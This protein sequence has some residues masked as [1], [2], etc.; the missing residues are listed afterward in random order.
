MSCSKGGKIPREQQ[1]LQKLNE[2]NMFSKFLYYSIMSEAQQAQ[3]SGTSASTSPPELTFSPE[4][5]RD[6]QSLEPDCSGVGRHDFSADDEF[7]F[8]DDSEVGVPIYCFDYDVI[9]L[10][11]IF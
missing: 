3:K 2:R 9:D 5:R 8:S 4:F 7:Y 11:F 6:T 1:S 10:F